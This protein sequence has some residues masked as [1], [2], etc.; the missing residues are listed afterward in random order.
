MFTRH[1]CKLNTFMYLIR[2]K[3]GGHLA[4]Y[5]RVWMSLLTLPIQAWQK[6]ARCTLNKINACLA[7]SFYRKWN[8]YELLPNDGEGYLTASQRIQCNTST[9]GGAIASMR[10][11]IYTPT[12]VVNRIYGLQITD[13]D[14]ER[15]W[16]IKITWGNPMNN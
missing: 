5:I 2:I 10:S 15:Q 14:H 8:I 12:L 9:L 13:L 16:I 7:V 3:L 1:T 11:M 4:Q 6:Q